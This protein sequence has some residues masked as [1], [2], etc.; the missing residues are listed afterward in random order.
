MMVEHFGNNVEAFSG[1]QNML[2]GS[3][4]SRRESDRRNIV[5]CLIG[6]SFAILE[7]LPSPYLLGDIIFP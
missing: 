2:D 6:V 5:T 3:A 7:V 4:T 1:L